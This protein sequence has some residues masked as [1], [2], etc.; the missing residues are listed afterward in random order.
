[1]PNIHRLLAVVAI[2]L[3]ALVISVPPNVSAADAKLPPD[4]ALIP[5]DAA[6]FVHVR[7]ADLARSEHYRELRQLLSKAGADALKSFNDRFVPTPASLDRV[8]VFFIAPGEGRREPEVVGIVTTSAPFRK[9]RLLKSMIQDQAK[10]EGGNVYTDANGLTALYVPNDRLFAIG[11]TDAIKKMAARG[12]STGE[13]PLAPALALAAGDKPFVAA[14][15]PGVIPPEA[16]RHAPPPIQPLVPLSS[17]KLVTL[18][19]DFDQGTHLDLQ[20]KFGS[21]N[22]ADDAERAARNGID[23]IRRQIG[24]GRAEMERKVGGPDAPNPA[25][26]GQLPEAA[27]SLFGLAVMNQADEILR[28]LPLHREGTDLRL[29]VTVPPGPATLAAAT[30]AVGV[31]LLLPAVQKVREA[32]ARSQSSNN[33]K[34]MALAMHNYNDAY[35]GKLPAHAIYSKDGKTPLLSWRVAILPFIEQDSLYRQFHL[36]E[37]WDSEHNKKLIP[38]MP[39]VYADLTAPPTREPDVTYYQIFVGGGA[40]WQNNPR[41]PSIPRTFVDGTSNTIMI[42][43]AAQPVIW[44]KPDDLTYDP[45]KPVPQLGPRPGMPFLVALADGSVRSISRAMSE[46]TLRAAITAAGNE[47]MGPDWR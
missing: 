47:P 28:T 1:V 45:T 2:T 15:N 23:M 31:G 43:E 8:T 18:V 20:A 6:G 4:I 22:A 21:E 3:I 38:L 41:Q 44:S 37:S 9:D 33:L 34:Q 42:A 25:P 29:N 39:P 17:A 10:D 40:A 26:I 24:Q 32:S 19:A 35:G 46:K 13:G 14:A 7:V 30:S 36:D 12:R 27:A 11:P 16:L 5:A